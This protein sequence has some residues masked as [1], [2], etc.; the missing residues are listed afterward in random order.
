MVNL[1]K[2]QD[3]EA[4][5]NNILHKAPVE[6]GVERVVITLL[7]DI[8]SDLGKW[9]GLSAEDTPT[10]YRGRL[11]QKFGCEYSIS[12]DGMILGSSVTYQQAGPKT[13]TLQP[14][15]LIETK[16]LDIDPYRAGGGSSRARALS[17]F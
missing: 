1:Q 3:Y 17:N 9:P 10:I 14:R 8:L 5:L 11:F 6:A 2:P 4:S 16:T 12:P 15:V 7:N 13:A